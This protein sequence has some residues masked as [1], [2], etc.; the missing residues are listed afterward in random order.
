[1]KWHMP[2]DISRYDCRPN[3]DEN[4]REALA[5]LVLEL[6]RRRKFPRQT[7]PT[8][9]RIL[10]P[11]DD[12]LAWFDPNPRMRN[13]VFRF[14]IREMHQQQ[15]TYWGWSEATWLTFLKPT[16]APTR[17]DI[18][19]HLMTVALVLVGFTNLRQALPFRPERYVSKVFGAEALCEAVETVCDQ[20]V[21]WGF[22]GKHVRLHVNRCLC[23]LF[24]KNRS[25]YLCDL[26]DSVL[27]WMYEEGAKF[28]ER[29]WVP[30]I[31]RVLAH[32]GIVSKPIE[33]DNPMQPAATTVADIPEA[34]LAWCNRWYDTTLVSGK[35]RKSAF[36]QLL[37]VGRWLYKTHP[38]VVSPADWTRDT[39][40]DA[41]AMIHRL[42]VGDYVSSAFHH[43]PTRFG[44]PMRPQ[45]KKSML[46]ALSLF[47]RDCQNWEWIPIRFDAA[48]CFAIPRSLSRLIGPSPRVI[49]DDVWA[50][51]LW[52]GMNLTEE[53]IPQIHIRHQLYPLAFFRAIAVMW[54]F[55]G[56]RLGEITRLRLGCIHWEP[57]VHRVEENTPPT[58]C[59]LDVPVT[60]T[61]T[62]FTK[63]VA[64]VVGTAVEAWE[65]VRPTQPLCVDT[66]TG[67][68]VHFLFAYRGKQVGHAFLNHTLIPI[69][70]R[71]AGIPESDARGRITSHRA[72]ATIA[73]QLANTRQPMSLLELQQWLGHQ[74]PN[75]TRWYVRPTPMRLTQSYTEAGYFD[76]NLRRIAVL[77]DQAAIRSGAAANGEA[78]RYYDLG[79]GYCTYDFFDQCPHRMA[80]AKCSFYVPKEDSRM[81]LLEAQGNLQRML[82]EIPLTDEEQAAVE[83]G[84]EALEKLERRLRDVPTPTGL[85]PRE[86]QNGS[87][88]VAL[89]ALFSPSSQD[90]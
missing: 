74:T 77:L 23:Y 26:N 37:K 87:G 88:F 71:K 44:Q 10:Q 84:M 79:H 25:P 19:H 82:Q 6:E 61:S 36:F 63:P 90:F 9:N 39:V 38:E 41:L 75:S 78:W 64:A 35:T 20:L 54:L 28:S 53:D 59:L 40:T 73:S 7:S 2:L 86:I 83:D 8:L 1:M 29:A 12:V 57:G 5:D 51:L 15:Q 30:R 31:S 58:V 65:K 62:A 11:L 60:K 27:W 18:N 76:R 4:E 22:S 21:S 72:R 67:E 17:K 52:A 70:C 55:A 14:C 80:C 81:H 50:K 47:F 56:L 49:A 89:E 3:L 85:T 66:K 69:L 24:V 43:N 32:L 16:D 34:W 45:S 46:S 42:Q 48:R 13:A 68:S 33:P